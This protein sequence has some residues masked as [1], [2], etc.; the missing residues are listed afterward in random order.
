ML[1]YVW[2]FSLSPD[3]YIFYSSS[4]S[5]FFIYFGHFV[6]IFFSRSIFVYRCVY[7]CFD[8]FDIR[9]DSDTLDSATIVWY[10]KRFNNWKA[11]KWHISVHF[12][13]SLQFS[14]KR[15]PFFFDSRRTNGTF[16]CHFD[17]LPIPIEI[18]LKIIKKRE[19]FYHVSDAYEIKSTTQKN[20]RIAKY[21]E[22]I[23]QSEREREKLNKINSIEV[24]HWC[25]RS[26]QW[27]C[28]AVLAQRT[29]TRAKDKQ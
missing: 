7:V 29:Y 2:C 21:K 14:L 23:L 4:V 24:L 17:P 28:F 10:L 8:C 1:I 11:K 25:W 6:Y 12:L 3:I 9:R 19:I 22:H 18:P 26:V 13:F 27:N 5:R 15:Q 20:K 16:S